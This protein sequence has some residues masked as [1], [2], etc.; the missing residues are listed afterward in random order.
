MSKLPKE[1][2]FL[3]LSDY[4]RPPARWIANALKKT[5][6]TPIHIT[7]LFIFAGIIAIAFILN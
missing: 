3:D 4:G 2:K 5:A 1:F 7:L 6:V